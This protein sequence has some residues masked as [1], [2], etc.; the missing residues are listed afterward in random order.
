MKILS[1]ITKIITL[2]FIIILLTGCNSNYQSLNNLGIV[3]SLLIDK[4]DDKYKAYIEVYKEEKSSNSTKS[5]SYFI[6]GTGNNIKD[7]I[8]NASLK[9]SKTLYFVHINAVIFS[10]NSINNSLNDIFNYLEKRIQLNSNYYILISDNVEELTKLKMK[11]N[12]ILGEKVKNI[13]EY[14]SNNGVTIK[15]D[16]LDKLYNFVS[17]NKDVFIN[18]VSKNKDGIIISNAYYFDDNKLKGELNNNELKLVNLYKNN[19]N[20]YFNLK[21]NNEYYVIKIDSSNIKYDMNNDINIKINVKASIDSS[22]SNLNLLK[23]ETIK[24]LNKD[25]SIELTKKMNELIKKLKKDHSDIL[26]ITEYIKKTKRKSN[27]NFYNDETTFN[28]S[29]SISKKGLIQNTIG[30]KIDEKWY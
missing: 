30:G 27:L 18:K 24:K 1:K 9:T 29:V 10:K 19:K 22:S 21:Y 28:I 5:S 4:I 25:A 11:D 8:N 3:S 17:P 15:Y 23:T 26:G 12:P 2:S 13:I 6:E 14:T 16:Y 20:I 7:A